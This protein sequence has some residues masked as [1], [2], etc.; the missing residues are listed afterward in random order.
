MVR[1][2][3]TLILRVVVLVE[4]Q[5]RRLDA[6]AVGL[7]NG[8]EVLATA[9]PALGVR[10]WCHEMKCDGCEWRPQAKDLLSAP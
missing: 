3:P 7:P 9:L 1:E 4:V 5:A 8:S 10:S 2:F 6:M